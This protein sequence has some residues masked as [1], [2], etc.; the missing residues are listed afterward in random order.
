VLDDLAVLIEA[1]D[2][3]AGVFV[4]TGP[5]LV[6][7]QN[8]IVVFGYHPLE[9]DALAGIFVSHPDEVVDERL[10]AVGNLRVVLDVRCP[11]VPLDGFGGAILVEH[12]VVELDRV[13]LV[14]LDPRV[15][16]CAIMANR[17]E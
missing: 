12:E 11:G 6:A 8:H 16:H 10:F 13:G 4:V 7:M 14:A 17:R 5:D 2:V 9:L 1:E 3:D 15:R